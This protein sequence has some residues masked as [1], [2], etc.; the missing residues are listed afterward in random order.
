MFAFQR[1]S[2]RFMIQ[3]NSTA[4]PGFRPRSGLRITHLHRLRGRSRQTEQARARAGPAPHP[5][6]CPDAEPEGGKP[7]YEVWLFEEVVEAIREHMR[8]LGNSKRAK[9]DFRYLCTSLSEMGCHQ[10]LL[11]EAMWVVA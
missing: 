8:T 6:W 4:C 5:A 3:M 9:L 2:Y 7:L 1:A 10:D 11:R